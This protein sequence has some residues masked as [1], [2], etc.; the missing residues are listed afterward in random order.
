MIKKPKLAAIPI[1]ALLLIILPL[2]PVQADDHQQQVIGLLESRPVEVTGVWVVA[3][4]SYEVNDSTIFKDNASSLDVGACTT[5]EFEVSNDVNIALSIAA[6]QDFE[7]GLGDD[8][9]KMQ[10]YGFLD[11]FPADMVG[12]WVVDGVTYSADEDTEFDQDHGAFAEG[13]CVDV[14]FQPD[15]NYLLEVETEYDYKCNGTDSQYNQAYGVLDSFPEGLIGEWVIDGQTYTAQT[16][17]PN[18][19][20]SMG[21]FL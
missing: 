13:I 19:N 6:A 18:L 8:M 7:C 10:A 14:K 2:L 9:P 20:R 16:R 12:E 1:L 11:S 3:G 15:T 4:K 17:K 5:V 21:R